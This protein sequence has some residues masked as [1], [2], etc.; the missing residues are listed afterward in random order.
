[1]HKVA[2]A[3]RVWLK[4]PG[5][6]ITCAMFLCRLSK[7]KEISVPNSRITPIRPDD[8]KNSCFGFISMSPDVSAEIISPAMLVISNSRDGG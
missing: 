3:Y 7:C 5:P 4:L 1:M 8:V 6:S 2:Q